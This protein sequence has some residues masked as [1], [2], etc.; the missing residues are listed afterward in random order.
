MPTPP[1]RPYARYKTAR[2]LQNK[3]DEY[4]KKGVATRD[5]IVTK[6]EKTTTIKQPLPTITGMIRYLGYSS[7]QSFYDLETHP[8]LG[9][10]IKAAK[11]RIEEAYE[12][13]LYDDDTSRARFMLTAFGFTKS[14]DDAPKGEGN[15]IVIILDSNVTV[16]GQAPAT[17]GHATARFT[18]KTAD[19]GS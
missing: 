18:I 9:E 15:K 3:V 6:D 7:R 13:Q 1:N 14:A 5:V 10:T 2:T 19:D 16:N 17:N 4:F 8:L 11:L 12:E